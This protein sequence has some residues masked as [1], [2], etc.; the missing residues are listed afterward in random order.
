[1]W[2]YGRTGTR[3]A[4]DKSTV[5]NTETMAET[6]PASVVIC[7]A[8]SMSYESHGSLLLVGISSKE[9]SEDTNKSID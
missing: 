4:L 5:S 1:M 2:G 7:L 3:G 9:V 6:A 8:V